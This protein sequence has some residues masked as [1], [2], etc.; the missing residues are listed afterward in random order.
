MNYTKAIEQ[1][2]SEIIQIKKR[3]Y[4]LKKEDNQYKK[5]IEDIIEENNTLKKK[6]LEQNDKFYEQFILLFYLFQISNGVN[7]SINNSKIDHVKIENA[8]K[9]E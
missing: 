1:L 6:L 5:K 9:S 3:L 8:S 4:E 2:G 7:I